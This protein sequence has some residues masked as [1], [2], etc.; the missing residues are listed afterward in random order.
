MTSKSSILFSLLYCV[1][2][3]SNVVGDHSGV[4]QLITDFNTKILGRFILLLYGNRYVLFTI[5][6]PSGL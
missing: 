4:E 2:Q 5:S 1:L 6:Y 3:D